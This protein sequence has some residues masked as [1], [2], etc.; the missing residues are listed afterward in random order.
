MVVLENIDEAEALLVALRLMDVQLLVVE[1]A[2]AP[3]DP[4]MLKVMLT[5]LLKDVVVD[6]EVDGGVV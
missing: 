3:E 2:N 6:A 1:G 4:N 5:P